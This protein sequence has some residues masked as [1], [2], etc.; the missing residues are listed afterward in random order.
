MAFDL[1]DRFSEV[2]AGTRRARAI[3]TL[4]IALAVTALVAIPLTER[5]VGS[6]KTDPSADPG[7]V[8]VDLIDTDPLQ[9]DGAT[10]NGLAF[11]SVNHPTASGVSFNIFPA[12]SDEP[13]LAS[14]D[15]TGP[16]FFPVTNDEGWGEPVD[17]TVL[18]NGTYELFTTLALPEGEQ[19]TAVTFVVANS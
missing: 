8:F 7:L 9:L 6:N 18:P 19:R 4:L 15:L 3:P 2:L 16:N 12:G 14:Q 10:V 13:V 11:I 1:S 17:T 5:A